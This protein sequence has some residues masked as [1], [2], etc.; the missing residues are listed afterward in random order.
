[1]NNDEYLSEELEGQK[2]VKKKVQK[3]V[4]I[5]AVL[6]FCAGLAETVGVEVL[7]FIKLFI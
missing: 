3:I 1:M 6:G 2:L 5:F 4:W 7:A